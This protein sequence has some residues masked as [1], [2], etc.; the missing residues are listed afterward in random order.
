MSNVRLFWTL[1][2]PSPRQRPISH[3]RIEAR[4]S[5]DL[6]WTPINEV[7]PPATDLVIQDAAPGEWFYRGIVVDTAGAESAAVAA[8]P[9]EV[10]FDGPS[11]LVAFAAEVV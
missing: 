4:V 10:P 1:P 2:T 8:E 11:A 6:P 9:V 3:V 7:A 5:S